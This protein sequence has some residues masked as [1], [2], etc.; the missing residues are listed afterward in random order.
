MSRKGF[1]GFP[2]GKLSV[3]RIPDLFFSELFPYIDNLP[4]LKV[5]LYIFWRIEHQRDRRP[6]VSFEEMASDPLLLEALDSGGTSPLDT[7]RKGLERAVSRGTLLLLKVEDG[8][9]EKELYF[10]NS[11]RGRQALEK[12]RKGELD[13]EALPQG[14]VTLKQARPNIFTLYEQNI[15]LISPLIAEELL[16]AEESY[17]AEWIEE[18][19]KIAVE[20]NVRNW[21]YIKRILERW[22]TEGKDDGKA[23]RA[24]EEDRYSILRGKY[25]RYI[26]H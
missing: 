26:K 7:L 8:G 18:A 5:T 19:F 3:I 21:K 22:A 4:E 23:G 10:L 15:G 17:P 20:R 1:G 2:A 13:L 9:E 11:E 16:E 25:A 14:Q 6:Y 12:A 24:P